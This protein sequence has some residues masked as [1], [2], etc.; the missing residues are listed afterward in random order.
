MA[1]SHHRRARGSL[2]RQEIL[3]AAADLVE[4]QGLQRFSMPTLAAQLGCGVASIYKYFPHK[5]ALLEALANRAVD[6]IGGQLPPTG[7]GPW[8]VELMAYFREFRAVLLSRA[9]Y[10]EL[11]AYGPASVVHHALTTAAQRRFE[12]GLALLRAAGLDRAAALDTFASCLNYTRGFV[13]LEQRGRGADEPIEQVP[14]DASA[15]ELAGLDV[16]G[17]ERFLHGLRLL[18][19]GIGTASAQLLPR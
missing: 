16:L 3:D 5:R 12:D 14:R 1:P 8:D 2:S 4:R 11:V 10:L 15:A 19:A 9:L 18:V 6:D 7:D 13:L 17:D